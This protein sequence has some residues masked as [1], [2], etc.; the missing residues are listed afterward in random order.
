MDLQMPGMEGGDLARRIRS[1]VETAGTALILLTSVPKRAE[2]A[3]MLETGFDAYLTKPVTASALRAAISNVLNERQDPA[4]SKNTTIF[5]DQTAGRKK[6]PPC[7]VLVVEDNSTNQKVAARM[8]QNA[9]CECDIAADGSKAVEAVTRV[10]YDL[11]F[12][13]CQMPL[14]DGYEATVE[15]RKREGEQRHTPVVAMTASVL[16]GDREKC[17]EAGMDDYICKPIDNA[18]LFRILEKYLP[19][20]STSSRAFSDSEIRPEARTGSTG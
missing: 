1:D 16:K 2:A 8:L 7:K 6:R 20:E 11:V 5:A 15:I 3:R 9:G 12:M 18:D 10:H 17:L 19:S 13:D 4:S 14:M